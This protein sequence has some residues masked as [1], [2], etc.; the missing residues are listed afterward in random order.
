MFFP[1]E[2]VEFKNWFFDFAVFANFDISIQT[3]VSKI[4]V[5]L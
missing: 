5:V 1:T 4:M 2:C 3:H